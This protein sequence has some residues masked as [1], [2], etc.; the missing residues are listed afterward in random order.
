[1]NLAIS[2]L[3]IFLIV[4]PAIL[5][6]RVYYTKELSKAFTTR[7]TLQEIFSAVFLSFVLHF[8]WSWLVNILGHPIDFKITLELLFAPDSIKSYNSITD[9]MPSIFLYFISLTTASMLFSFLMRNVIRTYKLDRKFKALRYDNNWYYIF[10]GE[11]LDINDYNKNTNVNSNQINDRIVDVLTKSGDKYVLY[12][13]NLV[14][15]QLNSNNSVDYIVLSSPRKQIVG[16]EDTVKDISSNYFVIPYNEILN[17]NIKYL[18]IEEDVE[19]S[20]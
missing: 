7:N 11:V 9:F 12:R 17:I 10:S 2:S 16:E 6:R 20:N 8:M 14:D 19:A 15:Y 18:T 1:M 5:A 13:G 4:S 3:I